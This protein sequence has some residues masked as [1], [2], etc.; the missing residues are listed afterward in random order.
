M[1]ENANTQ[2][3]RPPGPDSPST[4]RRDTRANPGVV[5][6]FGAN[7]P[8]IVRVATRDE[9]LLQAERQ[10]FGGERVVVYD[11]G[12]YGSK[13]REGANPVLIISQ[14]QSVQDALKPARRD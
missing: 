10:R 14:G 7:S 5:L 13:L 9:A 8:R 11:G 4:S 1:S 12:D 2:S 3:P 6:V